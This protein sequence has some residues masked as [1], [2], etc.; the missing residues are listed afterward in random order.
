ME[1]PAERVTVSAFALG[2]SLSPK[3]IDAQIKDFEQ[4]FISE[5]EAYLKSEEKGL[6]LIKEYGAIVF[7]GFSKN[8]QEVLLRDIFLFKEKLEDIPSENI[9]LE[10]SRFFEDSVEF[11]SVKLSDDAPDKIRVIMF[12]LA[13][14]VALDDY[15]EEVS[16]LLE[17]TKLV[18]IKLEKR[19]K[20]W[21]NSRRLRKYI[22][23]SL[24]LKNKIAENLFIYES[25][26]HVWDDESLSILDKEISEQ[27]DLS[28]RHDGLQNSLSAVKE[29]LDFFTT[30]SQHSHSSFLEW[31]IILLILF[32]V[33]QVIFEKIVQ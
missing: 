24:V 21:L 3:K 33:L 17:K 1:A 25:A 9:Q 13:Q 10:L 27:L 6:L 8:D 26:D 18:A 29:N 11:N 7:C 28:N 31:I 2:K 32:E 14:S 4:L 12:N 15:H 19:G 30:L 5:K 23:K 20:L 22:G 16:A